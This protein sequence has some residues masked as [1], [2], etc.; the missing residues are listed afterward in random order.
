MQQVGEQNTVRA[1]GKEP[2]G[3]RRG[4]VLS[5]VAVLFADN[6]TFN[7]WLAIG[8][9]LLG[10]NA[11][12][13]WWIG[14][15]LSYGE[16]RYGTKYRTAVARLEMSYDRLRDYA[17]VA[18]NVAPKNRRPELTFSHHRLVAS[19]EP[20][21]QRHWLAAAVDSK[22]T[23][24][25]FADALSVGS[26]ESARAHKPVGRINGRPERC[27]VLRLRPDSARI[28]L[29]TDAARRQGL[30][31][32]DWATLVLDEVATGGGS[33]HSTAVQLAD[34]ERGRRAPTVK[35]VVALLAQ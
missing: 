15:W 21:K 12:S 5:P 2:T 25:Q 32:I 4:Y 14:D 13:S 1:S 8:G 28:A 17:Y 34:Q 6:L 10:I 27:P 35:R 20:D 16:W 33:Q 24:R 30:D 26:V 22:W 7:E 31:V 18:A 23:K 3:N 19:L 9:R 29:W 11:A